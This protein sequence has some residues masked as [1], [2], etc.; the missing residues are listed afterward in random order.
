MLVWAMIC[1]KNPKSYNKYR[2]F[3]LA[4]LNEPM[5]CLSYMKITKE[6]H[7]NVYIYTQKM[8]KIRRFYK[9]TC[10][11]RAL[12]LFA[13]HYLVAASLSST[14]MQQ[15]FVK[16]KSTKQIFSIYDFPYMYVRWSSLY[17]SSI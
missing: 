9:Q 16:R 11:T 8:K 17:T 10:F 4:L 6:L 13:Q 2:S 12:R 14:N 15:V 5:C 7:S 1:E 3:S